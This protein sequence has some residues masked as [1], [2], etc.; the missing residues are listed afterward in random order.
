MFKNICGGILMMSARILSHRIL[1]YIL[2][3]FEVIN[4]VQEYVIEI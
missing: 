1:F 4:D 3:I 2:K